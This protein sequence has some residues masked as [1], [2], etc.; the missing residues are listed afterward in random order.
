MFRFLKRSPQPTIDLTKASPQDV[1]LMSRYIVSVKEREFIERSLGVP[2]YKF[3]DYKSYL[4]A[5]CKN[6]WVTFRCMR[7]IEARLL[8]AQFKMV[9]DGQDVDKPATAAFHEGG[10]LSSP[11]PYDSWEELIGY[12][13]WHLGLTGVAYWLK[14]EVDLLGR[15][16]ALYPLLPHLMKVIPSKKKKI[17]HYEYHVNGH[18]IEFQPEDIIMFK[19]THPMDLH[20]GL[21]DIEGSEAL[22]Q[23]FINKDTLN[24]K[25]MQHGAQPSGILHR[26]DAVEDE[27]QW[28][29]LKEKWEEDYGGKENAGKTAFLNGDWNYIKLGMTMAEMQALEKARWTTEQ[30]CLNHGVPLSVF[31]IKNAQNYATSRQEEINFRKYTVVPLIDVIVGKLNSDGFIQAN[32]PGL[33]LSYELEGLVDIEAISKAYGPLVDKGVMTRNEMRELAGLPIV[34]DPLMDMF[35]VNFQVIP[36]EMA[37]LANPNDSQLDQRLL[38]DGNAVVYEDDEEEDDDE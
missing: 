33:Q 19:R 10:F 15:P 30:I 31:G 23:D 37:G 22:L 28:K 18:T 24:E 32:R 4:K 17:N 2:I 16:T 29:A 36:L 7:L 27:E 12:T 3:S 38:E 35:T 1:A 20:M 8:S 13:C 26:K 9:H 11:N 21:G 5:G 34:D 25:F 6:V 14:D